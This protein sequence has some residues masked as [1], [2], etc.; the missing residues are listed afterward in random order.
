MRQL[1]KFGPGTEDRDLS[2]DFSAAEYLR[3]NPDVATAVQD[4]KSGP[5]R[6][7]T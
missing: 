4:G 1:L 7:T 6:T 5:P 3:L 2:K